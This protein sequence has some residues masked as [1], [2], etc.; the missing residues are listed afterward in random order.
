M[1]RIP[2]RSL[3][4]ALTAALVAVFAHP[5]APVADD[6]LSGAATLVRTRWGTTP[7]G[8][9]RIV[10]QLDREAEYLT[11][12]LADDDG[13]EVH[14][15]GAES[16]PLPAPVPVGSGGVRE[17]TFRPGPSGVVARI[18]GAGTPLV[19]RT[20]R[21][22]G[23]PRVVLDVTREDGELAPPAPRA[24]LT[25]AVATKSAPASPPAA[26]AAPVEDLGDEDAAILAEAP[27]GTEPPTPESAAVDGTD[28]PFQELVA[29][30]A[31]LKSDANALKESAT[32]QERSRHRRSLAILLAERGM[33]HEA[34]TILASA[35]ES[36][37]GDRKTAFA[38]SLYLAE[39]RLETGNTDGAAGIAQ[40]LSAREQTPQQRIRL[41]RILSRCKFPDLA[42]A[43]LEEALPRLVGAPRVEAQLLLARAYWDRKDVE[44]ARQ[45]VAKLT[46]SE[47]VPE[48]L[49]G[50]ALVLEA[51]CAWM[52]GRTGES[53]RLY[54]RALR[55]TLDDEASSWVT[56]QLGNAAR[57][58]GRVADAIDHY[59][60]ARDRWPDTFFGAQADWFLR[61]AE[62]TEQLANAEA[63]RDRG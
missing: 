49:V 16:E 60:E 8:A 22:E 19:A 42:V 43:N 25:G 57:R 35:L 7:R 61:V 54:R 20:F 1:A 27:A 51:D 9:T 48:E 5:V 2:A 41:A 3:G 47:H 46:E 52:L 30:I 39:L 59:R 45:Y 6:S 32:E 40:E 17:I 18:S 12:E 28:G 44:K 55:E 24:E 36:G 37:L 15:L 58:T 56:L 11:I 23:P 62:Q 26:A 38:D 29:W 13:I 50:E 4:L 21:L 31:A 34:E 14:L 33:V 53:E 10:F 63:L